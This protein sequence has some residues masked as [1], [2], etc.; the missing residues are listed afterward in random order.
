MYNEQYYNFLNCRNY[1]KATYFDEDLMYCLS[2]VVLSFRVTLTN[3]SDLLLTKTH[4]LNVKVDVDRG[5]HVLF[6]V[7][8]TAYHPVGMFTKLY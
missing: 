8:S 2:F 3:M 5:N 6:L 4:L 7:S 1:N